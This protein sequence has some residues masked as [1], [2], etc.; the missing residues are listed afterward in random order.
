MARRILQTAHHKTLITNGS[1]GAC[2]NFST[3]VFR[4]NAY[5]NLI[6]TLWLR[7][8]RDNA[9]GSRTVISTNLYFH[10]HQ[11]QSTRKE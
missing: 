9:T 7:L 10:T 6:L 2:L 3:S 5:P 4:I 8:I 1:E 11:Q